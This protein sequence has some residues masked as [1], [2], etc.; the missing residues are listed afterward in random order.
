MGGK[1][2]SGLVSACILMKLYP[3]LTVEDALEYVD[4]F[5]GVR[6]WSKLSIDRDEKEATE[7]RK[8]E[9]WRGR[10]PETEEQREQ[11]REFYEWIRRQK[12]EEEG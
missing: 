9:W 7:E 10:S 12:E 11:V 1:G 2:R 4:L 3:D 8:M 6:Q 5:C